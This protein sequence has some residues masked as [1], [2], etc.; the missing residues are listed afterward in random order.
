MI[1]T[2][3]NNDSTIN[4]SLDN[5]KNGRYVLGGATEVSSFALEMWDAN[6][7]PP[8]PSDIVYYVE[9]K[10]EG[11]PHLLGYI[12]YG[13]TGLWWVICAY[14][15]IIDPI[16]E[17]IEGRALLIPTLDRIKAQILSGNYKIGGTPTTR[18][19]VN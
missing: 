9:K 8:D 19:T 4:N 17:I 13:D 15:V 14:N 11:K 5:S 10:Y 18:S 1:T 16:Q 6:T 7:L 2:T 3:Q 12:F